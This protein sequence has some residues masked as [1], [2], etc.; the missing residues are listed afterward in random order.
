[1]KLPYSARINYSFVIEVWNPKPYF[2]YWLCS[3][4]LLT[5]RDHHSILLFNMI[6]LLT[7]T[8]EQ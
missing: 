3:L 8:Y 1:M 4:I 6:R 7:L 5:F 2:P